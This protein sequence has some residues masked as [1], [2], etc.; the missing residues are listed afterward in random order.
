MKRIEDRLALPNL[1]YEGRLPRLPVH[2]GPLTEALPKMRRLLYI[3]AALRLG[4]KF[5]SSAWRKEAEKY[6]EEIKE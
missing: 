2:E 1:D 3:N 4:S 5:G 6:Q